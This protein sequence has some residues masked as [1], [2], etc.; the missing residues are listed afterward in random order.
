[1]TLNTCA[2]I[3]SIT[4]F[5]KIIDGFAEGGLKGGLLS[6]LSEIKG[7]F[8]NAV[9]FWDKNGPAI[10]AAVKDTFNTLK[11]IFDSIW[12]EIKPIFI[13]LL[14]GMWVAFKEWFFGKNAETLAKEGQDRKNAKV[15]I[16]VDEA[17]YRDQ[18]AYELGPNA[19][20]IA[21]D[22]RGRELMEAQM[23]QSRSL[24]SLG[25]TGKL[26]ENWGA[27]TDVTLHGTEAVVTPEQMGGIINNSLAGELQTLNRQVAELLKYNKETAEYARRNVDATTSLSGNLFA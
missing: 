18:A 26:F 2:S 9:T 6:I 21:I 15:A 23:N 8:S 20:K 16:K 14:D 3:S 25:V 24:G 5:S 10:V 11:P 13:D 17:K 19:S 7:F 27:G 22:K 12:K 4:S 1:M